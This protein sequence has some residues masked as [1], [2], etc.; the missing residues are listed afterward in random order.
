M[1]LFSIILSIF[2]TEPTKYGAE[3]NIQ[4]ILDATV[5]REV[6]NSFRTLKQEHIGKYLLWI[7]RN[8][9]ACNIFCFVDRVS[10]YNRFQMKPTRCT[11][12]LSSYI[13]FNISTCFEQLCAHHQESLLYLCNT[14][15]FLS[16]CVAVWSAAADQTATHTERKIPVSHRY[17]KFSWW[18]AHSRPKHVEKLK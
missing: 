15:I 9:W 17:S 8:R 7:H 10:L 13:Y 18:W 2:S 14:G 12:L 5:V 4:E 11:L 3:L 6:R 16:V 1:E